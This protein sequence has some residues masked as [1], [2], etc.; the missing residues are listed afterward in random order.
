M[1]VGY[2]LKDEIENYNVTLDVK[3][4]V[5]EARS[6]KAAPG[7]LLLDASTVKSAGSVWKEATVAATGSNK[8]VGSKVKFTTGRLVTL[9]GKQYIAVA[10]AATR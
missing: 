4:G 7:Q 3:K 2:Q 10:S 5:T 1:L 8:A 6:V 9:N